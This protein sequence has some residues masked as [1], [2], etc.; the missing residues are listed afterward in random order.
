MSFYYLYIF[1]NFYWR[2]LLFAFNLDFIFQTYVVFSTE[3]VRP[4][5]HSPSGAAK[6]T[7]HI[8]VPSILSTTFGTGSSGLI[9]QLKVILGHLTRTR[10]LFNLFPLIRM[11][12]SPFF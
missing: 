6:P 1:L 4:I 2:C 12:C 11:Y 3:Q 9:Q 8:A 10:K 5:L 7:S